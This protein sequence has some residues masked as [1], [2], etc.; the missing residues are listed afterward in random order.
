[1]PLATPHVHDRMHN[2]GVEGQIQIVPLNECEIKNQTILVQLVGANISSC[3]QI[4]WQDCLNKIV[5][6]LHC[7]RAQQ[8]FLL[9]AKSFPSVSSLAQYLLSSS[10]CCI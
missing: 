10:V 8:S 1:M 9:P 2:F 6:I 5:G 4:P 3:A 7:G